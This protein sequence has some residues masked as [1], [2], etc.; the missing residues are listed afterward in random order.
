MAKRNIL[1]SLSLVMK[2]WN[3][4]INFGISKDC[5]MA[6]SRKIQ[7]TSIRML[8][9]I[10]LN[11]KW[12]FCKTCCLHGSLLCYCPRYNQYEII[13]LCG[14][15]KNYQMVWYDILV[16]SNKDWSVFLLSNLNRVHRTGNYMFKFDNTNTRTKC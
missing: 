7:K 3:L 11:Q 13:F 2:Q 16:T 9:I 8:F 5:W 4:S 14:Y 1:L 10:P 15:V 12:S 6:E